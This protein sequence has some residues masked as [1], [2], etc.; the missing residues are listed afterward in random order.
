M[1]LAIFDL[2]NTLLRGDSDHLW[3]RFL[4]KRGVVDGPEY[5][6]A[7]DRFY[8]QYLDGT[9]DPRA[10]LRFALD[11]LTRHA[12]E[13]LDAWRQE[14]VRDWIRPL[15]LP[16]GVNLVQR[17]A[18]QGD[19]TLIITATNRFITAPIAELFRVDALLASTPEWRNG[20]YTG[21]IT[22][23]ITFGS[24]KVHALEEWLQEQDNDLRG[25]YFY[26]DS[27]NDLPL[28]HRVDHPVA[29]DP[30]DTLDATAR[31]RGWRRISLRGDP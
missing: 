8:R 15:V 22:G 11:P 5:E 26:S 9:L 20:R 10:Y 16:E 7:N 29:V 21:E 6:A 1:A 25:S 24:G 23:P 31:E 14:F 4:V 27:H 13:Q 19:R 30:D 28:L 17:H 3:G 12:P 18:A 2:D